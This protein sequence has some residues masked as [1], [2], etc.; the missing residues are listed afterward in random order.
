MELAVCL[1]LLG[2]WFFS[3]LVLSAVVHR[4]PKD[5]DRPT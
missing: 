2:V 1:L 3:D 5:P 4:K